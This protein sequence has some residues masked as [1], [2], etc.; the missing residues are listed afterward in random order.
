MKQGSRLYVKVVAGCI[1]AVGL[2]L[3]APAQAAVAWCH[4][5][6]NQC[7]ADL[8]SFCHDNGCSAMGATCAF[9][10]C[11]SLEGNWYSHRIDCGAAT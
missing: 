6:W 3:P 8:Q 11:R 1:I 2:M 7:P 10:E 4:W 9:E 5:C